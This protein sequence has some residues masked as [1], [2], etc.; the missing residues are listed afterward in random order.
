MT[1]T[2]IIMTTD[3]GRG[4]TTADWADHGGETEG[5]QYIWMAFVSPTVSLRGEWRDGSYVSDD[6]EERKPALATDVE[7]L[8]FEQATRLNAALERL[9]PERASDVDLYFLAFAG[10]GDQDVFMK[11]AHFAQKVVA[12]RYR[13]GRRSLHLINNPKTLKESPLASRTNLR[14]ALSALGRIMDVENDILFLFITSHGTED[15]EIVVQLGDLPLKNLSAV[16]LAEMLE[17]SR[18]KWKIIVLSACYSGGFIKSLM[19]DSTLVITAAS[20]ERVSFGCN[21]EADLTFFGRAFFEHSLPQSKSLTDA[22]TR[23]IGVVEDME[24]KAGYGHSDP[25]IAQSAALLRQL[26]KYR[27]QRSL[28]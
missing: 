22:F 16:E 28:E 17:A 6:D 25:Q 12:S 23:A 20:P 4:N 18:I 1:G 14:A 24:D 13:L 15:H 11:E 2:A 26:A 9:E 10:D 3:H 27:E 8:L 5:A 21:D 7:T 19:D